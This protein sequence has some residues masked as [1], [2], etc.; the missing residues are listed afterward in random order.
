MVV[1]GLDYQWDQSIIESVWWMKRLRGAE[2]VE[3][4]QRIYEF[5]LSAR[6]CFPCIIIIIDLSLIYLLMRPLSPI[7]ST[8]PLPRPRITF[9][10]PPSPLKE[11]HS[12]LTP[13]SPYTPAIP[14][15]PCHTISEPCLPLDDK[16]RNCPKQVFQFVYLRQLTRKWKMK[17]EDFARIVP[18]SK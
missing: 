15:S 6:N 3:E 11:R 14:Y 13:H 7:R 10:Y 5:A 1:V 18:S 2:E 12:N 8:S 9:N 17:K 16:C 4:S